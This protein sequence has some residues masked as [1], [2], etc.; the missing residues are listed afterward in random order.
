MYYVSHL[1]IATYTCSYNNYYIYNFVWEDQREINGGQY[2]YLI[3]PSRGQYIYIALC[4]GQYPNIATG[5]L[6]DT[7]FCSKYCMDCICIVLINPLYSE[8][9]GFDGGFQ[10]NITK[11]FDHQITVL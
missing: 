10:Y 5:P 2:T 4:R 3:L 1:D 7:K 6:F 9:I 8:P 11:C